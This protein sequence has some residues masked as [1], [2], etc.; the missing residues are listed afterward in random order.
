MSGQN[1]EQVWNNADYV[2]GLILCPSCKHELFYIE[3]DPQAVRG[4]EA[5]CDEC[6]E[7]VFRANALIGNEQ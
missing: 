7:A 5:E 3:V 4:F 6:G 1:L 2:S